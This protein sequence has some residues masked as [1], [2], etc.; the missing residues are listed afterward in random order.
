MFSRQRVKRNHGSVLVLTTALFLGIVLAIC[1][2]SM[3]LTRMTGSHQEQKTAIEAAALA[4][5]DDLSRIV[6]E[7]PNFGFISL[8]D[9]PPTQAGTIAGDHYCT[10][11]QSINT[12]M[13]R[14]RLDMII[15]D[16][17]QNTTMKKL[18]ANE[19]Q[20]ARQAAD[21][22]SAT[23][24]SAV[25]PGGW[26]R[27]AD[28]TTIRPYN[29]AQQAYLSNKIRMNGGRSSL[30][31]DSLKLMLGLANGLSTNTPV[32]NPVSVAKLN[33]ST[34]ME[35]NS[36]LPFVDV[37]YDGYDFVFSGGDD[38]TTLV[39]VKAFSTNTAQL[40]FAVLNIIKCEAD[41]LTEYKNEYA[42]TE[43]ATLHIA[44]CA[45]PACVRD[46]LPNE[47]ALAIRFSSGTF[48][49]VA[50]L[51]D[52]LVNPRIQYSPADT[53]GSPIS[54]DYP[55]TP[56][57]PMVLIDATSTHPPFG[58][59]VTLALYDW[60]RNQGLNINVGSLINSF[61][62]QFD[63]SIP[64][65]VPQVHYF[66]ASTGG[67]IIET[68][69]VDDPTLALPVSQNQY[70]AVSGEAISTAITPSALITNNKQWFDIFVRDFVYKTGRVKGGAHAGTAFGIL[71][72]TIPAAT[73]PTP[74]P[75]DE[76]ATRYA[77]YSASATIGAVRPT[78][79]EM[80][81]AVE[82]RFKGR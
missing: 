76:A 33:S 29:D 24:T 47:S 37:P 28:G 64:T 19:Y 4:A 25:L 22:L 6:I 45:Q 16:Q 55:Q 58:Q 72:T 27:G 3:S 30:K 41:E 42:E 5:A 53:V 17:L 78:Y 14:I 70:Y 48:P 69:Q 63:A 18:L 66:R 1:L 10:S 38:G 49:E 11:V 26:A 21:R 15:A 35:N 23:L 67:N 8:S 62:N 52:L 71:G 80:G 13:A 54:G 9:S 50:R 75:L 61:N 34:M 82:I 7:D 43:A 68:V 79:L 32:P 40:P 39:D 65:N 74:P 36:Y 59:V 73:S 2:F 44:A 31:H 56:L 20:L 60:I 81:T 46:P 57:S 51:G 12:L 77:M